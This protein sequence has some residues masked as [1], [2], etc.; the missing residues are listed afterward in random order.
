MT[1]YA[2]TQIVNSTLK[3]TSNQWRGTLQRCASYSSGNFKLIAITTFCKI[4]NLYK[5]KHIISS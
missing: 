5:I 3:N 4:V 2:E 1:H